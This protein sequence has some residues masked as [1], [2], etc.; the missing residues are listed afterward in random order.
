MVNAKE[1]C[2]R[3]LRCS[4]L[5]IEAPVGYASSFERQFD[6]LRC[7][8]SRTKPPNRK[9]INI[10][11]VGAAYKNIKTSLVWERMATW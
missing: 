4:L 3:R 5:T 2:V 6:A 7:I 11:H 1:L 9:L 10:V 8:I